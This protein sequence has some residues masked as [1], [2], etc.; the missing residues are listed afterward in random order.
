MMAEAL[1]NESTTITRTVKQTQTAADWA[2]APDFPDNLT[3]D[4][5]T[6]TAG[7]VWTLTITKDASGLVTGVNAILGAG[8]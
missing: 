6:G 4:A 5:P 2:T 7:Q 1:T 8:S 3:V